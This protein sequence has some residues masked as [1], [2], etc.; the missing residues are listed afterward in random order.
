MEA[1]YHFSL[2]NVVPI[3]HEQNVI[4]SKTRLDGTTHEK[5]INCRKLFA[6]HVV[7]FRLM[8][9]KKK[10]KILLVVTRSRAQHV[11][12]LANGLHLHKNVTCVDCSNNRAMTCSSR[13]SFFRCVKKVSREWNCKCFHVTFTNLFFHILSTINMPSVSL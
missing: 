9:T 8:E 7:G 6:G 13:L 10:Y 2:E 5:T 1:I 11:P 4:C 3:T 12:R